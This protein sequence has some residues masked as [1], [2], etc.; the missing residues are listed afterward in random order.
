MVKYSTLILALT[1]SVSALSKV[2]AEDLAESL[3]QAKTEVAKVEEQSRTVMSTL[4]EINQRM[5]HMSKRRDN[6]NNR[7][8]SVEGNV[9]TLMSSK[10][11]L[12]AR[13]AQQRRLLSKRLRAMYMLGD[14]PLVRTIFSSTSSQD[15]EKSVKYLKLIAQEDHKL[16]QSYEKN[17]KTLR[18]RSKRLE[19]EVAKLTNIKDRMRDQ[20]KVLER[21]QNSKK[22]ILGQL[23]VSKEQNL[24][25]LNGLRKKAAAQQLD[26]LLNTTFFENKGKLESPVSAPLTRGYGLVENDDF[27]YRLAHKGY[28]YDTKPNEAVHAVFA[29]RVAYVGQIPGYGATIVVDHSD[30]FYTVYSNNTSA[31]VSQGVI[32]KAGDTVA[33]SGSGLYFEIRHFSDAVDPGQWLASKERLQ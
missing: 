16:I 24:A 17:L 21:D 14:Q 3:T 9:K 31:T 4:Y 29:G 27:H 12:E 6:L 33:Q 26:D 30:H 13:I 22:T 18:E 11:D 7:M 20:E 15:L 25:K 32:V 8:I 1:V 5:K 19:R 23:K 28:S 2:H 10:Q